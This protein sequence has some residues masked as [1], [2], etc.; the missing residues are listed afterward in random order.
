MNFDI[1]NHT[2]LLTRAGSRAYGIHNESSDVDIKGA[3]IPPKSFILGLDMFEQADSQEHFKDE[4][5]LSLLTAA[6]Q[7]VVKETK[8]EGSIYELRK[9]VKLALDNNPNILDLLFCRDEDVLLWG[10][11]IERRNV[12]PAGDSFAADLE[13]LVNQ[14]RAPL[15]Y[16]P[17]VNIE[18]AAK[19]RTL[20]FLLREARGLFLSS[21]CKHTFSGYAI[22]Q[23]K[24]INLH[25]RW[26]L[27]PPSHKPT[28]AEHELPE[29]TLIPADQLAAAFSMVQKKLDSWELDLSMVPGDSERINIMGQLQ[30]TMSEAIAGVLT[31][32]TPQKVEDEKFRSA[33]KAVGI[34]DNLLLIMERERKY[35]GAKA[36][37]DNYENWKKTRNPDRAALEAKYG[38]DTKHGAHLVR[39]MRMCREIL[40]DGK[41][42]VNR[43]GIDADEIL[44]IRKGAWSYDKLIEFSDAEEKKLDEIYKAGKYAVPK[45]PDRK[46][47][48]KL[49]VAMMERA[50]DAYNTLKLED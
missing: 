17:I 21:K 30:A 26:L 42:N 4:R 24:R 8:L 1:F 32:A 38:Y 28:R 41:V 6:E 45:Q 22:A 40:V 47:V 27:K 2:I 46:A 19:A 15:V 49:V 12:R 20:G 14:D 5:W 10:F 9:F 50:V 13:G 36:E 25:R 7:G 16:S 29:S 23:L 34:D 44:A 11:E 48:G 3:L 37:W 39:L 18:Q 35:K 43:Q 33:V 31:N